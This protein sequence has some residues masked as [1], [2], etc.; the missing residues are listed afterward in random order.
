MPHILAVELSSR[1]FADTLRA[2]PPGAEPENVATL[3][4]DWDKNKWQVRTRLAEW[5]NIFHLSQGVVTTHHGFFFGDSDQ[6]LSAPSGADF[7]LLQN[8]GMN[9]QAKLSGIALFGPNPRAKQTS[10]GGV[11]NAYLYYTYFWRKLRGQ[12]MT[13]RERV[14]EMFAIA[15]DR[16]GQQIGG[17]VLAQI[18]GLATGE[19]LF[20]MGA[21]L[22]MFA[23][24]AGLGLEG[25]AVALRVLCGVTDVATNW[26]LYKPYWDRFAQQINTGSD[27]DYGAQALATL[28]GGLLGYG[29]ATAVGGKLSEKAAPKAQR[30]GNKFANAVRN[31]SPQRWKIAA[32][33]GVEE[34]RQQAKESGDEHNTKID[35][36]KDLTPEER[37][38]IAKH[39]PELLAKVRELASK[40]GYPPNIA[41]GY[42]M[43]AYR[44][45][46][47]IFA[48]TSKKSSIPHHLLGAEN[49]TGKSLYV[50]Y[51]IDP[52]YG[53]ILE[54]WGR[55][56]ETDFYSTHSYAAK[57]IE[58]IYY[59]ENPGAPKGF[60]VT[61]EVMRAFRAQHK[62]EFREVKIG[63]TAQKVL[64]H[65]GKMV[66]GD[67]DLMGIYVKRGND[68]VPLP[69][70][71]IHNDAAFLQDFINRN[72]GGVP[73]SFHGQQ[74]VGRS[75]KGK[76]FRA[77]DA[78]EDYA[79]F[80]PDLTL[81]EVKG[82]ASLERLYR[83]LHVDWPYETYLGV[84]EAVK[85]FAVAEMRKKTA[86]SR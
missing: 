49:V 26:M 1:S 16:Y 42:A 79:M 39:Q 40:F 64:Y 59:A 41:E 18:R 27:L 19:S 31:N 55:N 66:I 60:E 25:L 68:L 17:D 48:R 28:L 75:S 46:W 32:Q 47:T 30:L 62:F 85:H 44:N 33:R 24:I 35:P 7:M 12:E 43:L 50:E 29:A 56:V 51:K 67:V 23:T 15:T 37:A 80:S 86:P 34:L 20:S 36:A 83:E 9:P 6:C 4:V 84:R 21:I 73:Q 10:A 45:G 22:L 76:P 3:W 57:Q 61:P 53:V 77:P 63:G 69:Q 74:D 70:W 81:R 78:G 82:T 5:M 71:M 65:N 54:A 52:T 11:A 58:A 72:V 13:K 2:P 38:T 8:Y 14:E